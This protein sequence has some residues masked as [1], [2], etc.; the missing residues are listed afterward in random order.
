MESFVG[1]LPFGILNMSSHCF[2]NFMISDEKSTVNLIEV[3][4][5]FSLLSR[6]SLG[7]P[8]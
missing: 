7:L 2:P 6:F 4:G 5:H 8:F 3:M 1:S